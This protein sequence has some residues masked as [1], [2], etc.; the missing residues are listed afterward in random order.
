MFPALFAA[1]IGVSM[2]TSMLQAQEQARQM[3]EQARISELQGQINLEQAESQARM[4]MK[5]GIE[6]S[7]FVRRQS[8]RAVG[9]MAAERGASGIELGG[10]PMIAMAEQIYVDEVAA[11]RSITNAFGRATSI[12]GKGRA[13][14]A[15]AESNASMLRES[16]RFVESA[17]WLN[18]AAQGAKGAATYYGMTGGSGPPGGSGPRGKYSP[19]DS[20]Y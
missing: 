5:Q 14:Q 17:A 4:A 18:V 3:R 12:R 6:E 20:D 1:A 7:V 9:A 13:D 8:R 2:Y 15:A 19:Y 11:G 10:S 16:A